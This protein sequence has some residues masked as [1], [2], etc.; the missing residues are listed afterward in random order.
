MLYFNHYS[1]KLEKQELNEMRRR[2]D[3]GKGKEEIVLATINEE[4]LIGR[5]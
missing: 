2:S 1:L 3:N 4:D 5:R